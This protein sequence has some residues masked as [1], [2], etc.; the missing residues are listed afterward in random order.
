MRKL[1]V[2]SERDIDEGLI[3]FAAPLWKKRGGADGL[4]KG[5]RRINAPRCNYETREKQSGG[6]CPL[7]P[8]L[9]LER[10][11]YPSGMKWRKVVEPVVP[12]RHDPNGMFN[13]REMKFPD[14]GGVE[15][16]KR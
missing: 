7:L 5:G 15:R 8:L 9:S 10:D 14:R 3:P 6:F 11:I 2:I 4:L 16:K 1:I 13:A 12:D